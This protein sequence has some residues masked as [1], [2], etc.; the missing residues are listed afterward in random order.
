MNHKTFEKCIDKEPDFF[1][2]KKLHDQPINRRK[3]SHLNKKRK[4]LFH[5]GI[6]KKKPSELE[7]FDKLQI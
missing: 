7:V 2:S 6:D 4:V 5:F 1:F 3:Y